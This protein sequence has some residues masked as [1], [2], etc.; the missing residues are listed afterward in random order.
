[1]AKR[2]NIFLASTYKI[3]PTRNTSVIQ[4]PRLLLISFA[5]ITASPAGV[6]DDSGTWVWQRFVC[7]IF[8]KGDTAVK[9]LAIT[10]VH[11]RVNSL[12]LHGCLAQQMCDWVKS[13]CDVHREVSPLKLKA[14][15]DQ[16]CNSTMHLGS[17]AC[18]VGVEAAKLV[19]GA[20][21]FQSADNC[22]LCMLQLRSLKKCNM[23][24]EAHLRTLPPET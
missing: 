19:K 10:I 18:E 11:V 3:E 6:E 1:V 22:N 16:W 12:V 21:R 9:K 7:S 2:Q 23:K 24:V 8:I 13:A 20:T 14:P 15:V 17:I 4:K 5:C